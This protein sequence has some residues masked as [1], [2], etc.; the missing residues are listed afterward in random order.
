[1]RSALASWVR[2]AFSLGIVATFLTACGGGDPFNSS[3]S[4]TTPPGSVAPP[5]TPA[6]TT[7]SPTPAPGNS[8]PTITGS[9][10]TSVPAGQAYSFTPSAKDAEHDKISFTIANKPKWAQFN[11]TT[12]ALSGTPAEGDVGSY[13]G[14]EIAATDGD[15]ITALP[16]FD[17][18]VMPAAMSVP[19]TVTVAWSAP[20]QNDDGTTL[21]DLSGYRIH[22]G[23]ES[24][25]YTETVAVKNPGLTRF[26]LEQLPAGTHFIAMTA[27]NAAGAESEYSRE[28]KITVN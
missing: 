26:I 4:A 8:A 13:K 27:Y 6:P 7:P 16:Q 1:M 3:T 10:V 15:N 2:L 12:G 18:T 22:Y 25:N 23:S 20:T 5:T 9:A 24:Q 14:I 28:V 11:A 19:G 21:S 17:L